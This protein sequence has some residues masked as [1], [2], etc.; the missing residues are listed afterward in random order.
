[1]RNGITGGKVEGNIPN[2]AVGVGIGIFAEWERSDEWKQ[3]LYDI[4]VSPFTL[5]FATIGPIVS[6]GTSFKV[7]AKMSGNIHARKC[8]PIRSPSNEES[9]IAMAKLHTTSSNTNISRRCRCQV[10]KHKIFLRLRYQE[11][12]AEWIQAQVH[13]SRVRGRRPTWVDRQLWNPSCPRAR[14]N[15]WTLLCMQRIYRYRDRPNPR[16]KC[17]S[18]SAGN[19]RP[20]DQESRLWYEASWWL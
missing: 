2:L 16:G 18:G 11:I 15:S 7:G 5:G 17:H 1:M 10:R 4:P 14:I 6:I 13:H 8:T 20:Q 3:N 12:R 19:L 9:R